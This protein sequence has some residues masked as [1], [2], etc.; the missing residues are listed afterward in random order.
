MWKENNDASKVHSCPQV[1]YMYF[2]EY[3]TSNII[4]YLLL[5]IHG[6]RYILVT[7][8]FIPS[9]GP[10]SLVN[11]TEE[12]Q[13]G[14]GSIFSVKCSFCGHLN[15]VKS[16]GEHRAGS[17]GPLV[18]DINTR[19][20]LGSLHAG[21]GNTH[22]NNLLSTINIPTM[23]HQ[24]FKRREREVGNALEN[25]ARESCKINLNLEKKM[26]E[27]SSSASADGLVGIAVSY[28]MGWQKR[29][30]GHNSSTGHGA[31]M[32]LATGKVVSY[33][34]RCKTCR[35]C[36]HNKST[37]KGKKHDCR[38][39]HWGSSKS[40]ERDVACE[41]WSKAPQ[42]GVKF[43]VYV[44]DDDSTTLAD[45][46]NKV[47]YGVEKWSDIVHAKRSLNTRLY[48][49][50]D[51]FK[52]SNCSILSPKVINYLTK[53]FSYCI[54]Q[55]IGDSESIKQG[56]KNIIPHAFG[57]HTYCDVSWCGYKQNPETYKHTDLPNGKDLFGDSLKKALMDILEEYSTDT[58]VN[59]LAP[60]AYSQRNE[61]LNSS[62][63][64][65]NPKTRF[66][67]GSESNDF[68]VACGVAQTNIGYNYIGKTL[69]VLNIEPGSYYYKHAKAMDKKVIYDKQRK[70]KR[71]FKRRRNQLSRQ[72]NSQTLRREA[73][74]GI[75]Y[76][77]SIGLN[78]DT[79][80]DKTES[81]IA[82]DVPAKI[83]TTELRGYEE[84]IPPYTVRPKIVNSSYDSTQ[85][86][87]FIIFDTETTCT[88]KL[89]EICQLSA[90]SENGRHE[91]SAFILPQS[92]ISYSA[93]LVNGMTIKNIKGVRTLCQRN[94]PVQSVTIEEALRD[95]LRFITQVKNSDQHSNP[96]TVLIGHNSATFDVPIL[97]RNGDKNFKDSITDMNVYFADSLHLV[98]KLIKDKHKAL[99]LDTGGY[100]KPNQGSLY[101]H[102]FK[103]QFDAHDAL[104]DVK[105][106]RRIIFESSLRLSRKYIVENSSVTSAPH[107]VENM[108]HLDRRHKLLLTF[109]D[110][111]FNA[112]DTG[113]IKRS[114][115]QNIAD[116]GLSYDDL[117]KLY[118]T[119]G[120]R[121]LVA[122]LSNPPTTSS[123][124]TPRVT[125][126]KR[127]LAAIVKHFD[128][129]NHEE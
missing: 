109:S 46:K 115:A 66:Y 61:S 98:K 64:S 116:S 25:I 42:S 12:K 38:K 99:E 123:A 102:L 114:M 117:R 90:V 106:L 65:K 30:R 47:P 19:A 2:L 23:N 6:L 13:S 91:F 52:G 63:G 59:K 111:L 45:I 124:R 74:E 93:Y 1:K 51:R 60:C 56:L 16:S 122:I 96:V 125:R 70:E 110:K 126:T 27:Q 3:G 83:S 54:N 69:E 112:T 94:N 17:R 34:T 53:C 24:L 105:A 50:K 29:G 127:I 84:I 58:V 82:F 33:S 26:A 20:V 18:N 101:T 48:N 100:C 9:T 35:V 57:E 31:A 71:E 86:Y 21:M 11:I 120:K 75:T 8:S 104:E 108:L 15:E 103:E 80:N 72:K 10:L 73:S 89:A 88:G 81:Q 55:N 4:Y 113:P 44:G 32:G 36:S 22:L 79:S 67:G 41:L 87:Q 118:T 121:A 37:G 39:N 129:N 76:E 49:L 62:I 128:G 7:R 95:F 28:D 107:A 43:S 97:L 119:S 5:C 78:L 14:L 92:N 85:K 77:S 40:M 68:R